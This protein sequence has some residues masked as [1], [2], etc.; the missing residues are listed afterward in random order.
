[1]ARIH[2]N[3]DGGVRVDMPYTGVSLLEVDKLPVY[4]GNAPL[5]ALAQYKKGCTA[6]F[7]YVGVHRQIFPTS[8][9]LAYDTCVGTTLVLLRQAA[10]TVLSCVARRD[11][12]VSN[13]SKIDN[14][15]MQ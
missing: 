9:S 11:V 14:N 12:R 4:R 1:M 5:L 6:A 13:G 2:C 3:S 15:K 7:R 8:I 10:H